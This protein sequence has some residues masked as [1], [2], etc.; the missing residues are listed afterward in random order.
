MH[1]IQ[2]FIRI[3]KPLQH[4]C[5]F[6]LDLFLTVMLKTNMGKKQLDIS[7]IEDFIKT[8][9]R[10]ELLFVNR[11]V[12]DRLN[13]LSQERSTKL[14]MRFSVGEK[15]EFTSRYGDQKTGTIIKLNK[16]TVSI[17]TNDD[18]HWNVA[19]GLLKHTK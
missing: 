17:H 7:R 8:L 16:K 3:F 15:V 13:L 1:Y 18:E 11:M 2:A 9:D 10:D 5:I 12:I 4:I 14:M 6:H 19:P